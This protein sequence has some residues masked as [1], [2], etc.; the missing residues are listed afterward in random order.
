MGTL[1]ESCVFEQRIDCVLFRT[2]PADGQ[3]LYTRSDDEL[4]FLNLLVI[5]LARL[6]IRLRCADGPEVH[7][8]HASEEFIVFESPRIS[9]D[10]M[11]NSESESNNLGSVETACGGHGQL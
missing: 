5:A 8:S 1:D 3:V 6:H 9:F 2:Q 4:D 7:Q 11:V 10:L